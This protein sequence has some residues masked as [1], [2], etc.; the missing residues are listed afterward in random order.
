[1]YSIKKRD[2]MREKKNGTIASGSVGLLV[3]GR[4][5]LGDHAQI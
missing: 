4:V 2:M 5:S 1:M 3:R